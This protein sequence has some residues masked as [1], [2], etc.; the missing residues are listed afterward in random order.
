MNLMENQSR[1]LVVDDDAD[2][3][4]NLRKILE[5]RNYAA[6][7]ACNGHD[8]VSLCR[9]THYDIALVDIQLGPD[10]GHDLVENLA[11]ISPSIEC[12]FITGHASLE[13]AIEAVK[14][15]H[16]V[17]YETKPLDLDHLLAIIRQIIER[18]Q[19]E[20]ALGKSEE[21]YRLLMNTM[22]DALYVLDTSWTYILVNETAANYVGKSR[23]ELLNKKM[24]DVFPELEGT[25]FYEAMRDVMENRIFRS[26]TNTFVVNSV[27][28]WYEVR[29]HP[30]PDGILCLS[31]DITDRRQ[32]EE[33]IKKQARLLDVIFEHSLDS[34]VLLDNEYNF[35]RVS[36]TYAK[37]CQRDASEFP[38]H[39]HFELYPSPLKDEFDEAVKE[40]RIY[41]RTAR[42]FIFPDHPDWGT[43]YWDLGLVPIPDHEGEIAVFLFTLKDV[44]AQ[45]RTEEQ[46]SASLKEKEVLLQEIHH[47]VKNNLQIIS[48]LLDMSSLR[49][50]DQEAID[51][52]TDARARIHIMALIHTQLYQSKQFDQIDMGSHIRELIRYLSA[53]YAGRKRI[54][55]VVEAADVCL[56]LTQAIPCALVLNELIANAF[57]HAFTEGQAGTLDI[58]MQQSS[59]DTIVLRVK[60]D[61]IGIRDDIDLEHTNTLGLKLIRKLV[62]QQLKG[63]IQVNRDAGTE[64]IITFKIR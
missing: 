56:A 27:L 20:E 52:L 53:V 39:N 13:S 47:R 36:E 24:L 1:I 61:G 35:I 28:Y 49:T 6:D 42:P 41:R 63:E 31:I 64:F 7:S 23:Q 40:K 50:R 17:S 4:A 33:H 26:V 21:K 3:C 30:V 57:K 46:I 19:A 48:S 44:T 5:M 37:A 15:E 38:G 59:D 9:K 60:D 29:I 55:S 11:R 34:I 45:V 51:L 43:T 12:I 54:R 10:S 58:T 62:Q 2:L 16:V 32:V 18:K 8:A 14:Q 25:E 22:S